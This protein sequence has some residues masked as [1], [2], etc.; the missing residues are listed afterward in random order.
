MTVPKEAHCTPCSHALATQSAIMVEAITKDPKIKFEH[1]T[2]LPKQKVA[3]ICGASFDDHQL[4]SS[5]QIAAP[6]TG[7]AY[8]TG[9]KDGGSS[10]A[11]D[12]ESDETAA[13]SEKHKYN[14]P[15]HTKSRISKH[16]QSSCQ[17]A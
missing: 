13:E 11:G 14:T 10:G 16:V 4:P 17:T 7:K 1:S 3:E 6:G 9:S 15:A 5:V 12:E 8:A 2:A